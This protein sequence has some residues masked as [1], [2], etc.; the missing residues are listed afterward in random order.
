MGFDPLWHHQSW[1]C[2]HED[3]G[4]KKRHTGNF[5]TM[6]FVIL[7]TP[8]N[9]LRPWVTSL[10]K[11]WSQV[12]FFLLGREGLE[13]KIP[14]GLII[15][16]DLT[17]HFLHQNIQHPLLFHNIMITNQPQGPLLKST[18]FHTHECVAH[19]CWLSVSQTITSKQNET[20]V[21]QKC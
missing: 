13:E 4:L 21:R 12:F 6:A 8:P 5:L 15:S 14:V 10:F 18:V 20:N 7:S 9:A 11:V 19:A 2:R 3:A 17:A 16:L 1:H